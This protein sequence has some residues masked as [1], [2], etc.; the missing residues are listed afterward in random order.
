MQAIVDVES[1]IS[2]V[3][4]L[5]FVSLGLVVGATKALLQTVLVNAPQVI[6]SVVDGLLVAVLAKKVWGCCK[7]CDILCFQL[8][9]GCIK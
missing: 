1:S 4:S 9:N 2:S 5:L 6:Y 8:E 7:E 3:S